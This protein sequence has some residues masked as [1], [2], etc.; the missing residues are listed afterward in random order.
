MSVHER[1][2]GTDAAAVRGADD[3]DPLRGRKFVGREDVANLVIENF[4][5]GAGERAQ[6]V[7]AQHRKIIGQRHAGEF[8]AVDNLHRR[9]SMDV[10]AGDGVLDGAENVAVMELWK[11]AGQAALDADFGGAKLPGFDGLL[12]HLI[13]GEEV[14]VRLAR[15]TAEGAEFASHETDVGEV[16]VAVDHVGDDVAGE[17]GA[18]D[19]R[20]DQQAEEI[21]AFG[22]GECVGLFQR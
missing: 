8:D 1:R 14:G 10:H 22:V 2:S 13:E 19:V 12:R 11:I 21:V 17:F 7:V 5:G 16:D 15:A 20:G 9:E 6:A 18:Q 3:L 4:C